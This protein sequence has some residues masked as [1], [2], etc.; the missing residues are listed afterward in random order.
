M[1]YLLI[2][3]QQ[4]AVLISQEFSIQIKVYTNI[5]HHNGHC[6]QQLEYYFHS[7][8]YIP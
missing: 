1:S 6:I 5:N 4:N 3:L 7:T 2:P 8:V